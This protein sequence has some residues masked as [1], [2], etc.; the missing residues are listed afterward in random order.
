MATWE[1]TTTVQAE[2][3]HVIDILTDPELVRR[4][5]PIDFRV[6]D[7]PGD[8]LEEGVRARVS[9][10]IAG[11]KV[12]FEIDVIEAGEN[13]LVLRATG[14]IDI[15]VEYLIEALEDAAEITASVAVR[16]GGGLVGRLLSR[17]TDSLLA[18][19]ALN[20]AVARIADE[21]E[22]QRPLALAA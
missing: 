20:K 9:G 1:S 17:A 8:R 10:G 11:Q 22:Q 16:P 6:E 18:A 21:V 12:R 19:G 3:R 4:W 7:L 15:D 14:P 13:G 5:S 2:P